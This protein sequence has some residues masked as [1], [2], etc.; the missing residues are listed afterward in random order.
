[1]KALL[2]LAILTTPSLNVR[3]QAID[4]TPRFSESIEDGVPLRQMSFFDGSHSIFYRPHFSW[5]Q[6]GDAESAI[7]KPKGSI[8]A[9]VK[10]ENSP[11]GHA[12][13]PLDESGLPI[14]RK[15]AATLLPPDAT[16]IVQTWEVVNPVV[17]QGWTSFEVGF[18]Y[19]KDERHFSRSVLFIN[20]DPT[21]QV[22]FVVSAAPDDFKPLYQTAYRTLATW[23]QSAKKN[24]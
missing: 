5:V 10:I 18:D 4:F 8:H 13:L 3:A 14:L 19:V 17:L 12:S 6:S 20:L 22:R 2:F 24:P 23:H 9:S 7:F 15:T 1:M 21:R 16:D 11:A